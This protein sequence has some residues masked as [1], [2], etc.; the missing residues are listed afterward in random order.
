MAK[1]SFCCSEKKRTHTHTS[2]HQKDD[3][4]K[5]IADFGFSG[6]WMLDVCPRVCTCKLF[7]NQSDRVPKILTGVGPE[8]S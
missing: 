2:I 6:V 5:A 1:R 7:A 4:L 3:K 8:M